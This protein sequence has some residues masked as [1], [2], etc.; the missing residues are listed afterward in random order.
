[1]RRSLMLTLGLAAAVI[2]TAAV[3][4]AAGHSGPR[5]LHVKPGQS[6]QRAIDRARPGDTILVAAGTYHENL[7][8]MKSHVT[9]RGAGDSA[10]GTVIEPARTPHPSIC[11]EFGEV[12]GICVT[13]YVDP[14]TREPGKRIHDVTVTGF[15][16]QGFTRFGILLY[17]A[18]DLTVQ[19]NEVSG[20]GKYGISAYDLTGVKY[21]DN[22][23][24]DNTGGGLQ[25]GD[26]PKADAELRGNHVY[27]NGT[28]GGIGIFL[29]DTSHG[30]VA[31][32]RVEGN[33][34]G[35]I[36]LR[37]DTPTGDWKLLGNTVRDNSRACEPAEEGGPPLSGLGIGLLG[38]NDTTVT[39][40]T[41]TGN[42]PGEDT[43]IVGGLLIASSESLGGADPARVSAHGNTLRGNAPADL[44]SDGSGTRIRLGGN[45]C[46]TSLPDGLCR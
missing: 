29:R 27:G 10:R 23:V 42:R 38:A 19:D 44:V 21:L 18:V 20:S 5:T 1:M 36:L 2:T 6:I 25:I 40:N 26:A 14:V 7:T 45:E 33:C 17:D 9:L 12:N 28:E 24:H 15:G 3:G 8:I 35:V 31:D 41:V 37:T 30:V 32:N 34:V 22:V 11:N 43:P 46:S 13:G 16:V 39:G 4:A